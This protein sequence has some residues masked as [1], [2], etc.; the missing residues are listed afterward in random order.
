FVLTYA[1]L[2]LV[3][4]QRLARSIIRTLRKMR[5]MKLADRMHKVSLILSELKQNKGAMF[6]AGLLS[7]LLQV[8]VIVYTYIVA[9]SVNLKIPVVDFFAIVPIILLILIL[10]VSI[11]G[12]GLR[13]NAYAFM[14]AGYITGE[15]AVALSWVLLALNL[16]LGA[17]GGLFYIG[18]R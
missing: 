6:R 13:E 4:N 1:C 10:P 12:I 14:F 16:F 11:N 15:Q 2:I 18:R 17:I 9:V 8:N 7:L 3:L 5:F